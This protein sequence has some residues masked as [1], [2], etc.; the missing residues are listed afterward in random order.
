VCLLG[1]TEKEFWHM[2]TRKTIAVFE[3]Y[4]KWHGYGPKEEKQV[5]ISEL[6]GGG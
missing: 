1:F 4:C 3:Q 6:L 2:T 5:P